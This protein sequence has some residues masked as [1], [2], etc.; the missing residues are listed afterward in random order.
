MLADVLKEWFGGRTPRAVSQKVK[1]CRQGHIDRET[2][3]NIARGMAPEDAHNAALRKFGNLARV[4]EATWEVWS[5]QRELYSR[6]GRH[7]GF[8][9]NEARP[10]RYANPGLLA[11]VRMLC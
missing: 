4:K 2:E 5:G 11:P 1:E 10:Y 7:N 6:F 9:L 8:A 3:D